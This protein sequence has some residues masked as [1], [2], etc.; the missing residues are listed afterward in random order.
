MIELD[1]RG[2]IGSLIAFA[3]A[4]PAIVRPTS[5]MPVKVMKPLVTVDVTH[6]VPLKT[7]WQVVGVDHRMTDGGR[8]VSKLRLLETIFVDDGL[9]SLPLVSVLPKDKVHSVDVNYFPEVISSIFGPPVVDYLRP[10][11]AVIE[12]DASVA[13]Q[14]SPSPHSSGQ[15]V[16]LPEL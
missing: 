4:A 2:F 16:E 3:A 12:V 13:L 5:I 6:L 8:A 11:E 14:Y 9:A 7:L 10:G 15:F 1:R